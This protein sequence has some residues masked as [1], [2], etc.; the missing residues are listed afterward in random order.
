MKNKILVFVTAMLFSGCNSTKQLKETSNDLMA[1]IVGQ[2]FKVYYSKRDI[3]KRLYRSYRKL[4][5]K[6]MLMANKNEDFNPFDVE[7]KGVPDRRF[8]F[9]AN[10]ASREYELFV[11]EEGGVGLKNYCIISKKEEGGEGSIL[12][13]YLFRRANDIDELKEI[14]AK[15]D[16]RIKS[17]RRIYGNNTITALK[18]ELNGSEEVKFSTF[19]SCN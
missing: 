7:W 18:K 11:Y 19:H 9:G 1:S 8:I 5:E 15:K 10:S 14:I 4:Y 17:R 3:P 16:Y 13:V 6:G 2:G 12:K